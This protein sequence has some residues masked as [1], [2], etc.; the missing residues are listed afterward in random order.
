METSGVIGHRPRS[1][2]TIRTHS[3]RGRVQVRPKPLGLARGRTRGVCPT[4][5]RLIV[6]WGRGGGG[7]A[8]PW[9]PRAYFGIANSHE[10]VA[11]QE[12]GSY[13][14]MA[15]SG[16]IGVAYSYTHLRQCCTQV[17]NIKRDQTYDFTVW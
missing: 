10:R 11:E 9:T 2:D 13:Q 12:G 4:Q 15:T 16:G 8:T 3:W 14:E 7:G 17:C 6:A 5:R 1:A